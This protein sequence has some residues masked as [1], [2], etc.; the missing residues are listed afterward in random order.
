MQLVGLCFLVGRSVLSRCLISCELRGGLGLGGQ[1]G[2]V[3]S[4]V[5]L[6]LRGLS[7]SGMC[8]L[9]SSMVNPFRLTD[10]LWYV[11]CRGSYAQVGGCN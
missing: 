2:L 7:L 6:G 3:A 5:R 10:S 1:I 9:T 11:G 8:F 4:I